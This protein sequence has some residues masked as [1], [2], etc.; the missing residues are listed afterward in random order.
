MRLTPE[1][2]AEARAAMQKYFG[3]IQA[4]PWRCPQSV[5]AFM[6][7]GRRDF[8]PSEA[9][10]VQEAA[11]IEEQQIKSVALDINNNQYERAKAWWPTPQ[12]V[13]AEIYKKGLDYA[14]QNYNYERKSA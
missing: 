8:A 14:V 4:E 6:V 9:D 7:H 3:V 2:R 11:A 12:D 10:K 13:P 5:S 1:Q